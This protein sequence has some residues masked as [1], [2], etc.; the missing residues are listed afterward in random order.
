[1]IRRPFAVYYEGS[2]YEEVLKK[3]NDSEAEVTNVSMHY[4]GSIEK[5]D[6]GHIKCTISYKAFQEVEI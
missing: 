5:N 4:L 1:M 2:R 3:L 6:Y